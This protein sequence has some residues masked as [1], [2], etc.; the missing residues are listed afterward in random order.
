MIIAD[1]RR[2]DT[3]ERLMISPLSPFLILTLSLVGLAILFGKLPA[4]KR[5]FYVGILTWSRWLPVCAVTIYIAILG[6]QFTSSSNLHTVF[7]LSSYLSKVEIVALF[8]IGPFFLT[9]LGNVLASGT[10]LYF[11]FRLIFLEKP[12]HSSVSIYL[13]FGCMTVIALLADKL[14]WLRSQIAQ[15]FGHKLRQSMIFVLAVSFISASLLA[16]IKIQALSFWLKNVL[17]ISSPAPFLLVLI[18]LIALGW[19]SISIGLTRHLTMLLIALPSLIVLAF[20]T[21]WPSYLLVVPFTACLALALAAADRRHAN[22]RQI[23]N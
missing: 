21:A 8:A 5:S 17:S 15:S 23:P 12:I 3:Q 6:L 16:L 11:L 14:P 1:D 2:R 18:I 19:L 20:V 9:Q 4:L 10:L 13:L 7:D 22:R